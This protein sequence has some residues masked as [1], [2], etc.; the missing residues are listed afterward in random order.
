MCIFP[1]AGNW[2]SFW[3][4]SHQQNTRRLSFSYWPTGVQMAAQGHLWLRSIDEVS[5]AIE[6]L[7]MDW[8]RFHGNHLVKWRHFGMVEK[9]TFLSLLGSSTGTGWAPDLRFCRLGRGIRVLEDA[10][11]FDEAVDTSDAL[12]T[13]SSWSTFIGTVS[14][15]VLLRVPFPSDAGEGVTGSV[16]STNILWDIDHSISIE[17]TWLIAVVWHSTQSTAI[18]AHIC[19]YWFV[20]YEIK[21]IDDCRWSYEGH[22]RIGWSHNMLQ[23]SPKNEDEWSWNVSCFTWQK[24]QQELTAVN[25]FCGSRAVSWSFSQPLMLLRTSNRRI[26]ITMIDWRRLHLLDVLIRSPFLEQ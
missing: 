2:F 23:T 14:A 19:R 25:K 9:I 20:D 6:I 7:P 26:L 22:L 10:H 13:S 11:W 21:L 5:K 1:R 12:R 18:A 15:S 24:Q 3:K 4:Y 8:D 17:C 16:V